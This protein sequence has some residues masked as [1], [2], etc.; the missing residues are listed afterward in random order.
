VTTINPK[1]TKSW[2]PNAFVLSLIT[3]FHNI[4]E[5]IVSVFFGADDDTLVLLGF[6]VDSFAEVIS[7]IGIAHMVFRMRK[8]DITVHDVFE[9]REL[10]ITALLFICSRA[11]CCLASSFL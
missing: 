4:A 9:R 8:T 7:G 2:L 5:G 11:D 6:G 10:R 3:I 1:D